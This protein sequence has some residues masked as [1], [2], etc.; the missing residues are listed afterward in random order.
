MLSNENGLG[1][2]NIKKL[3]EIQKA[4]KERGEIEKES[5]KERQK[6]RY[7]E[8]DRQSSISRKEEESVK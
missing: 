8:I 1:A 6:E 7:F 5:E 4:K 3:R 2:S